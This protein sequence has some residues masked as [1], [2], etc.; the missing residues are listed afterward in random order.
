MGCHPGYVGE[1]ALAEWLRKR[2]VRL[3]E[4]KVGR[5]RAR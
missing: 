3:I 1:V 5:W 2:V 4:R